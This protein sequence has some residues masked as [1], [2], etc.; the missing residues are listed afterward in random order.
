LS[1]K[2]YQTLDDQGLINSIIK[3][4]AGWRDMLSTLL[5]RHHSSLLTRCYVYLKNREDAEDATQE[6]E[7]RVFRAIKNFRGDS[8]FR[9]WL[10]SIADR[11]CYDLTRKRARQIINN[12]LRT[13]IEIH[14]TNLNKIMPTTEHHNIINHVLTRLPQQERDVIMLRYYM[15]LSLQEISSTLGIGLSAT[16]MRL[17]R[18]LDKFTMLLHVEQR[19]PCA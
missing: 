12:H 7:L 15:D 1:Q 4:Q 8:S 14:E 10:F 3:Q 16:K 11:Q 18:A 13:L 19:A 5:L 6:T 2:H 17:Y 9:T